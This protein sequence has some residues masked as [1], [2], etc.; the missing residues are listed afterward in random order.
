MTSHRTQKIFDSVKKV[1]TL[2]ATISGIILLFIT[3]AIF[4]DVFLR[5]FFNRPSIWVTEVSTYLFLYLIFL[6]TSYALQNG[7]HIRVTFLLGYFSQKAK[8]IIEIITS[9]FALTFSTVLLWQTSIMTWTAFSEDWTSP[10]MLNAPFAYIYIIMVIGSSL[11]VLTF[12]G[13]IIL[14]VSSEKIRDQM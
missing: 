6:A 2:A 13:N 7:L 10:T 14:M 5:Y 4:V 3:I 9:L 12:L 11:L 8:R 1:N